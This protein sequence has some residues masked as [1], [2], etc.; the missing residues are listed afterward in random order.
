MKKVSKDKSKKSTG[1]VAKDAHEDLNEF[2]KTRNTIAEMIR[3][4]NSHDLSTDKAKL[5]DYRHRAIDAINHLFDE[6]DG[7]EGK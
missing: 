4:R 7:P 3:Y 6:T 5:D 2:I 1:S